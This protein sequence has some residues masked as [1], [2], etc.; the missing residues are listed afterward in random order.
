LRLRR[1]D[2]EAVSGPPCGENHLI[3]GVTEDAPP[4]AKHISYQLK[5]DGRLAKTGRSC[6]YTVVKDPSGAVL[7]VELARPG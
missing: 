5:T 6:P 4:R 1:T 2:T 3:V 7:R